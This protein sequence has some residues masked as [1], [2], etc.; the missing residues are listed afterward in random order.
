MDKE[1]KDIPNIFSLNNFIYTKER[2][3]RFFIIDYNLKPTRNK[4]M[5]DNTGYNEK[6]DINKV[7]IENENKK[8]SYDHAFSNHS[9]KYQDVKRKKIMDPTSSINCEEETHSNNNKF[10]SLE[11]VF[12]NND[13]NSINNIEDIIKDNGDDNDNDYSNN[14]DDD[15]NDDDDND[16]DDNDDDDITINKNYYYFNENND[17]NKEM[18]EKISYIE[19]YIDKK[20]SEISDKNDKIDHKD[21][22][23]IV[24]NSFN[25][26]KPYNS[27]EKYFNLKNK[28]NSEMETQE[29][30]PKN[31]LK[32]CFEIT[33]S[34]T[35]KLKKIIHVFNKNKIIF[36]FFLAWCF[37]EIGIIYLIFYVDEG[38]NEYL[39]N[40]KYFRDLLLESSK[41]YLAVSPYLTK[42]N[43]MLQEAEDS[44]K[45][46]TKKLI[47]KDIL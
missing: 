14:S 29:E 12:M 10:Q 44:V 2:K 33:N 26:S 23:F 34:V 8:R 19:N 40:A 32:K 4:D 41:A 15:D 31:M 30:N 5:I 43:E 35:K 1:N 46:N 22:F 16:D 9:D 27:I 42:Y 38:K 20:N 3:D 45:N 24:L 39:E 17:N 47:I 18:M 28:G 11:E 21:E 7:K 37:Y 6:Q 25:D 13:E 36:N